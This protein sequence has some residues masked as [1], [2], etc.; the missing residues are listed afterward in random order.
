MVETAVGNFWPAPT[1]QLWPTPDSSLICGKVKMRWDCFRGG[2][3]TE[4]AFQ[5]VN[6]KHC[7]STGHLQEQDPEFHALFVF[8]SVFLMASF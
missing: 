7:R 5:N 4:T 3:C 6:V 1:S 2:V 8:C